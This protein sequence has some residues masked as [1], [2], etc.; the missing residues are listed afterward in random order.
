[1]RK[2]L[3]VSS[4]EAGK[5]LDSFIANNLADISRTKVKELI[6]N[7]SV[8]VNN[9]SKKASYILKSS[10]IIELN[11]L[12]R[13]DFRLKPYPLKIEIL[14]ED[15]DVIIVNKPR[16]LTV[17]PPNKD[18]HNTL[19]NALTYM[20]KELS[21]INPLRRGVVHRLDKETSGVMILAKNNRAHL[22][23]IGQFKRR[24]IKKEYF[25]LV[26]GIIRDQHVTIDM[27]LRRDDN[28]RLK[29]KVSFLKAKQ[30]KTSLDVVKTFSDSTYV[31]LNPFTGRMHQIRVHLKFLGY[32]IVGDKKYG[33]KDNYDNLFLHARRLGFFHPKNDEFLEFSAPLPQRF[34]DFMKERENV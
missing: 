7:K 14:H 16:N 9:Q 17:H 3:H 34:L 11:I 31:K 32:P 18:S 27:P 25:A 29:M 6:E 15:N 33:I 26:W 21:N 19:I 24:V 5:R 20:E 10:D 8:L 30:A 23:L 22:N 13:E 1:M 12:D 2:T 4:D 28:N